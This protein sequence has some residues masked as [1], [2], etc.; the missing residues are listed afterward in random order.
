MDLQGKTVVIIGGSSGMGFATAKLAMENRASIV[1][2]SRSQEKL[3]D[4]VKKLGNIRA[5][6]ADIT[7]EPDIQALFTALEHVDHIFVTTGEAFFGK[8]ME[9][10]LET[11]R[12]DVEQRFW[13]PLFVVR[14]AAP[15]MTQG[16]ITF[17]SGLYG[18]KPEAETV[19]TSAMDAA[20]EML[21]KGLAL[22]LA[23]IRFNA[24]AP[25]GID[26]PFVAEF[27]EG[28]VQYGKEKLPVGRIGTAE[29]VAQ[30]VLMLMTNG[31][32]TGEVLHIDGGGRLI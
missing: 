7:R 8:I 26:T 19:V 3:A 27:I 22:E 1:I 29:E 14:H 32:I 4:A 25:G 13:G 12:N 9:T 6:T 16:S 21:V 18:S 31:F 10:P 11:F 23:P 17:L 15:K 24:V 28:M 20:I 2:A 30:A 5:I